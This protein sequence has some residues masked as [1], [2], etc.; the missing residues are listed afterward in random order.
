MNICDYDFMIKYKLN[1]LSPTKYENE[2]G[3]QVI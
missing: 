3:W 2:N 1:I